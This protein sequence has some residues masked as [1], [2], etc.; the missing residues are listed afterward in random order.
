MYRILLYR[1]TNVCGV[2]Y[3]SRPVGR[4]YEIWYLFL[5]RVE[6]FWTENGRFSISNW[7]SL[8]CWT[9]LLMYN[10]RDILFE[11]PMEADLRPDDFDINWAFQKMI[12]YKFH[13]N[14]LF[15]LSGSTIQNII[16]TIER[17]STNFF[18]WKFVATR[19]ETCIQ[20]ITKT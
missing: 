16:H 7:W 9:G 14:V 12:S 5:F 3:I 4:S 15:C 6:T 17:D 1:R 2:R 19:L 10:G 20:Y 13:T 8:T 18:I 11:W